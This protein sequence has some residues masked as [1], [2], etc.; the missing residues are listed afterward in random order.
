[1]DEVNIF[2]TNPSLWWLPQPKLKVPVQLVFAEKGPFIGRKFPQMVKKKFGIPY[3]V[4][5]GSHMF[6]LEKPQE[7]VDLIKSLIQSNTGHV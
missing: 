5:S 7:T 4:M 3:K 6:P 1:M 2:R